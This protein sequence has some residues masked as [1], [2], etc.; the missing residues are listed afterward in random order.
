MGLARS[1]ERREAGR[2]G[3]PRRGVLG[4]A[5]QIE[6]RQGKVNAR[7]GRGFRSGCSSPSRRKRSS[8]R[9]EAVTREPVD[10]RSRTAAGGGSGRGT[11][12]LAEGGAWNEVTTKLPVQAAMDS[13]CEREREPGG[14]SER[15]KN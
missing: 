10:V 4:L 15:K 5:G 13:T 14:V 9:K 11:S 12:I 1:V 7:Q 2:L 6:Q 3:R 8:S